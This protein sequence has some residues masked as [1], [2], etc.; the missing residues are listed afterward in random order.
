MPM[1]TSSGRRSSHPVFP[2]TVATRSVQVTVIMADLLARGCPLP[3]FPLLPFGIP[4]GLLS[5]GTRLKFSQSH[6][7]SC[8][9]G[10]FPGRIGSAVPLR[11]LLSPLQLLSGPFIAHLMNQR[12]TMDVPKSKHF[13]IQI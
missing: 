1:G 13:A 5:E 10:M 11:F 9:S 4:C 7:V 3:F 8:G 2:A 6:S 12:Y